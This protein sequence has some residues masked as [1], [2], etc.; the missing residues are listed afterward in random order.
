MSVRERLFFLAGT[1]CL[2]WVFVIVS[3]HSTSLVLAEPTI[4]NAGQGAPQ[5]MWFSPDGLLVAAYS[6]GLALTIVKYDPRT[7]K[8]PNS[9]LLD[10]RVLRKELGSVTGLTTNLPLPAPGV[11]IVGRSNRGRGSKLIY[12]ISADAKTIAWAEGSTV[13]VRSTRDFTGTKSAQSMVTA[14]ESVFS[15]VLTAEG[16]VS[17]MGPS[18]TLTTY[19]SGT[20][21]RLPPSIKLQ[22][23]RWQLSSR[24]PRIAAADFAGG[25]SGL[26]ILDPPAMLG[27][28]SKFPAI[29]FP[30]K[31]M[32]EGSQVVLADNK[33][34]LIG[35]RDGLITRVAYGREGRVK[36]SLLLPTGGGV[37]AIAPLGGG[38]FV[39]GG[40]FSGVFLVSRF[41]LV[42]LIAAG[43]AGVRRIAVNGD[44]IALATDR[45]LLV[46]RRTFSVRLDESGKYWIG[47][48]LSIIGVLGFYQTFL[49]DRGRRPRSSN[50]IDALAELGAETMV[51]PSPPT[52]T[53]A[54]PASSPPGVPPATAP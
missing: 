22:T 49:G 6:R 10:F 5:D 11:E 44:Y 36:T 33:Q 41:R 46:M 34:L 25:Q 7:A 42:Q 31:E 26:V 24:G 19:S 52:H 53:P 29:S 50:R 21:E 16:L 47:L 23:G 38:D 12:A 3:C 28:E 37:R 15:V 2:L 20:Q 13:K 17:V 40:D 9:Q 35:G 4:V 14:D 39:V 45:E 30:G 43:P 54:S 27:K 51:S 1:L 32:A 8:P 48:M 18:G